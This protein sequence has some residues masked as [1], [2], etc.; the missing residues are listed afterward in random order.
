MLLKEAQDTSLPDNTKSKIFSD[1]KFPF[2]YKKVLQVSTEK[3][4]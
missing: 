2:S 3:A 4:I 1:V